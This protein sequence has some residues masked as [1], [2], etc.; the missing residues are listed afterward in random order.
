MATNT[1]T[2]FGRPQDKPALIPDIIPVI[3][4]RSVK[5]HSRNALIV[6]AMKNF[7]VTYILE[8]T[9]EWI[10]N[11]QIIVT[12]QHDVLITHPNDKLAILENS[13]P[14][15]EC[16]FLQLKPDT[17]DEEFKQLIHQLHGIGTRK[18]S[19]GDDNSAPFRR[20]VEEHLKSDTMS[21]PLCK[22]LAMDIIIRLHRC[23]GFT[24]K[25]NKTS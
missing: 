18:V 10:T 25:S 14:V 5:E 11:D 19:F 23:P 1:L 2:R 20:M 22:A 24:F 7:E 3:G 16:I 17:E 21:L 12:R 8:G 13:F 15:S 9:M 6:H 4:Q